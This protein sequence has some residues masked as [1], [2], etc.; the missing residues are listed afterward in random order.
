MGVRGAVGRPPY[1]AAAALLGWAD[2]HWQELRGRLVLAGHSPEAVDRL[3][4]ADVCDVA[5]AQLA[6]VADATDRDAAMFGH[7]PRARDALEEILGR[8]DTP[9]EEPVTNVVTLADWVNQVN[10]E[11]A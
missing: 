4:L 10:R 7:E 6:A 11:L 2:T 8:T 3:S 5:Y 9:E 1:T